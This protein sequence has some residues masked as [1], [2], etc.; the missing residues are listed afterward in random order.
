MILNLD[1]TASLWHMPDKSFE[2]I[3]VIDWGKTVISEAPD[4]LAVAE[5]MGSDEAKR[6]VNFFGRTEWRNHEVIFGIKREDRRKHVYAIG[7]TGAGKS[8]LIA[9]MA[10]ND[11]RNGEGLAVI[12]P[13]GDLCEMI[14][15]YVPK[16][17]LN[18]VIYL[19][20][21]YAEGR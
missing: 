13:H 8:T 10:I 21:T 4:E 18:D 20:P 16:R 3:K 6:E 17:R 2:K 5:I 14:L 9:N 7:K 12:D 19:D 11:I 15:K 1:E